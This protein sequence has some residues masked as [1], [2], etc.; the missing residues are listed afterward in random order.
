MQD[1]KFYGLLILVAIVLL[2]F[3]MCTSTISYNDGVCSVCGGHYEFI[4]AIG[5]KHTTSYLYICDQCGNKIEV[6]QYFGK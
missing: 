6:S 1:A 3:S 2:I 5:H 4:Q